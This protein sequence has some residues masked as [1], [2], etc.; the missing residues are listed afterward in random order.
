MD[1]ECEGQHR[2]DIIKDT[3][4]SIKE[5]KQ[6]YIRYLNTKSR[7]DLERNKNRELKEEQPERLSETG[8][9]III[10]LEIMGFGDYLKIPRKNE[11]K[12]IFFPFR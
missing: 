7:D 5:K 10:E 4:N 2:I 6:L 9:P 1:R 11:R 8:S 3:K 12:G